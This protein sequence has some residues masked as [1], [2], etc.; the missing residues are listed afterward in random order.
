MA[1]WCSGTLFIEKYF[2]KVL[3]EGQ[4]KGG[5]CVIELLSG[6]R[7][8]RSGTRTGVAPAHV[9]GVLVHA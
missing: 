4:G 3:D 5:H 8:A 9:D 2:V 1:V 7:A 6:E